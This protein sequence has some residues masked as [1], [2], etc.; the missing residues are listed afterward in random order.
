MTD[1]GKIDADFFERVVAPNLGAD[2]EAV[3]LGP[4]AG[5][6]FGVLELDGQAIVTATDPLSVLPA[7]GLERAGRLA[8]DIVL[9]DVAV[10][11]I[12]PTHLTVSLTLPP[13]YPPADLATLWQGIDAHA[14]ELGVSVTA[15]HAG[16]YPGVD[17]SWI[18]SGAAF[19]VGRPE[20]LVRPDGARPGDTLVISTGPAAEVAGLFSTLYP[21]Q[22]GLS[23]EAVRTAQQRLADIPAVADALAAHDAGH[24]TAMHDA[25]EGGIVGGLNEMADGADVRFEI[26]RDAVPM[27]EG[28]S[29]VCDAI[30]VDPWQVTSCGTLLIAVEPSDAPAVVSTLK[31]RDTPAAVVGQVT[32]GNGVYADG[33][34]VEPPV[35]DPSWAAASRLS[36]T[37]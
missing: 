2:R 9:S 7:L 30:G 10:S 32:A 26:D 4:T 11:G 24:V 33:E 22:L 19:G 34:R 18:G 28:V 17:S 31:D 29:A 8:I 6:D 25:T 15:S 27:A 16:R 1:L 21:N 20:D 37:S 5:I 12:R 35:A 13:E 36:D 14:R 3:S 23:P